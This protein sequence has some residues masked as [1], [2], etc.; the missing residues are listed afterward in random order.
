VRTPL[1][2]RHP[3]DTARSPEIISQPKGGKIV[4][5]GASIPA[6][7]IAISICASSVSMS[8]ILGSSKCVLPDRAIEAAD[9]DIHPSATRNAQTA[10]TTSMRVVRLSRSQEGAIIQIT[11]GSNPLASDR[12]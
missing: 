3:N 2:H 8:P 4:S 11:F 5:Q 6:I 12:R 1:K 7:A 9:T 10:A